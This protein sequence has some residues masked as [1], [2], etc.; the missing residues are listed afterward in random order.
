MWQIPN[1]RNVKISLYQKWQVAMI[2]AYSILWVAIFDSEMIALTY[3]D[4]SLHYS[5][6]I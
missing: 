2:K 1:F 5:D 6:L 4:F 3:D